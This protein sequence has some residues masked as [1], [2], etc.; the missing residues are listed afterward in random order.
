MALEQG[1]AGRG[2]AIGIVGDPGVGKGRLVRE[3]VADWE[4]RGIAVSASGWFFHGRDVPGQAAAARALQGAARHQRGRRPGHRPRPDRDS[5]GRHPRS[6]PHRG[7]PAPIFEFLGIP[8]WGLRRPRPSPSSSTAA[9]RLLL[10]RILEACSRQAPV[11]L[12]V[13]DL[14]WINRASA[15]F[16]ESLIGGLADT[17]ILLITTFRPEYDEEW[18]PHGRLALEP[19]DAGASR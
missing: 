8:A 11:V 5:A 1:L 16:L 4:A 6:G 13:E 17:R 12:V 3:F 10:A 9:S 18:A 19:L 2:R 7:P 15:A 14:H